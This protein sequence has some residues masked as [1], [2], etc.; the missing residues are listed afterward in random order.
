TTVT[1]TLA[2]TTTAPAPTTTAG[3]T[4]T[5]APATTT[6]V[7]SFPDALGMTWERLAADPVFDDAWI[8]AVT[9]GGPGLVAVGYVLEEPWPADWYS[10]AAVWV[11]SD[12]LAWERVD[13]AAALFPD[14][15]TTA[16][17]E[18]LLDVW[19][20]GDGL[21]AVGYDWP[22]P[23]HWTSPDG[24]N[25]SRVEP[26]LVGFPGRV[27][28]VGGR[29]V[30]VG[31]DG[32]WY[33]D[34]GVTWTRA[35]GDVFRLA[36]VYDA[37]AAGPGV[38]AVGRVIG[39]ENP[40]SAIWVSSDGVEWTLIQEGPVGLETQFEQVA[41]SPHGTRIL[42][43]GWDHALVSADGAS[44][45]V[46]EA[47]FGSPP[48]GSRTAWDGDRLV[49]VGRTWGSAA[50]VWV[51]DDGGAT[52]YRLGRGDPAFVADTPDISDVVLFGSR[53]IAVG[54]DRGSLQEGQIPG[55]SP[56]IGADGRGAVWIGTW[57]Q[58]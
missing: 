7:P 28:E 35:T 58:D 9:T 52:L 41:A 29:L 12:G 54:G 15:R 18:F 17:D 14:G 50:G 42:A 43:F 24:R 20:G 32:L 34:D 23:A 11:S 1:T 16:S 33:S 8:T 4:T 45:E 6:T 40:T 19:E 36:E 10:D 55:G 51:S 3:T 22:H 53:F 30:T 38:V 56:M 5:A 25:W 13:V 57:D 47:P 27:L 2:P 48:A 49:V 37:V 26:A 21:I 31:A 39:L 44:W 46:A